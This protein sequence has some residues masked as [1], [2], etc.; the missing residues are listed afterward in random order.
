MQLKRQGD[1]RMGG[2]GWRE[3]KEGK[4]RFTAA[5]R[6]VR[7]THSGASANDVSYFHVLKVPESPSFPHIA[8]FFPTFSL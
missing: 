1:K 4:S 6:R 8:C 5:K 2:G 3:R 7:F